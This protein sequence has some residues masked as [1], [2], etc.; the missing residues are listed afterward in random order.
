M[1]LRTGTALA[2][3]ALGLSFGVGCAARRKAKPNPGTVVTQAVAAQ[4]AEV[5]RRVLADGG[6]AID[7]AVAA[8]LAAGLVTPYNCGPGGYGGHLILKRSHEH[9]VRCID[10]NT[11]APGQARADMYPANAIGSLNRFGWLAVGVPGILAGLDL[12]LKRYGTRSFGEMAQPAIE[13]ARNGIVVTPGFAGRILLARA[14]LL[15]D[16]GSARGY[17]PGGAVPEP[18]ELF[19]NPELAELLSTLA[20]RGSVESFYR[21]DIAQRIAE[22]FQEHGGLVTAKDLAAYHAREIEPLRISLNECEVFT[23]PLTAGGLTVLQALQALREMG[24]AAEQSTHVA[25]SRTGVSPVSRGSSHQGA[26]ETPALL[27]TH[28]RLEALRLAWKDRLELL[29]DPQQIA[30]PV[31]R[32]LSTEYC[33]ELAMR[34]RM[35]SEQ[36]KLLEIQIGPESEPGTTNLS[37]VD[38]DGNLM[39]VTLTHGG[40]FGAQVTVEGL[41]LTLGHGMSRFNPHPGHPNAPGPHKRP[42]H[43]MCPSLVRRGDHRLLAL[44]GSG[45]T[46]IPNA[47]F[48]V[49]THYALLHDEIEAAMAAPRCHCTGTREVILERSWPEEQR[50]YLNQLGFDVRTGPSAFVSAVEFDSSDGKIRCAVR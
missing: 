34:A 14:R 1:L 21:G 3:G 37:S 9:R 11:M 17:L 48:D 2:G 24:W 22:A 20:Q 40:S 32:L 30:V 46:K 16:P 25:E 33:R 42:I 31:S 8:A 36:R 39:A 18:G 7:A 12:V 47:I 49:L 10:F 38:G 26:G 6:N 35:A 28:A 4:A 13:L 50:Q 29:G 23:A 41:G 15:K 5:G 45:G 19:R 44:G 27:A 43:N